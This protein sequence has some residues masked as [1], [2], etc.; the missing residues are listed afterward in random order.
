MDDKTFSRRRF[1]QK[2]L[3]GSLAVGLTSASG[4][5]AAE[6][7]ADSPEVA[8]LS[9]AVT[10]DAKQGFYVTVL[11]DGRAIAQHSKGGEFSAYFQNEERSVEDRVAP[12]KATLWNGNSQRLTTRGECKLR[13]LNTTVYA[14]VD[15]AVVTPHVLR[16]KIRLQQS[17]MFM[18]HYQLSNRLEAAEEPAKFWS[19][20]HLDWLGESSR[21][22]FP[23]GGFRTKNGL[24]VG[25]LTDS[26]Y[27]NQWT[28]IIRRDGR[29]VKPAPARI[30]DANL[31]SAARRE[32]R[33]Q[34]D[35]FI[36]QTFGELL[37]QLPGDVNGRPITLPDISSWKKHGNAALEAVGGVAALST[38]NSETGVLIP[39]TAESPALYS[40]DVQY[41]SPASIAIE[42]WNVDEQL[43]KITYITLYNDGL[44]PSR[45]T[46]NDF[47]TTVFVP[48]L[49]GNRF[50][51]FISVAPSEQGK[52][53]DAPSDSSSIEIQGLRIG[54]VVTRSQPYHRLEMGQA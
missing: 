17:D 46:W 34:G 43:R 37:E 8:G 16:K 42:I 35:F 7:A 22:Y 48:G 9:L 2:S 15:Y 27:R 23:A 53:A 12:W 24:C 20:D 47:K 28:R 33:D 52:T 39:F 21:E 51:V 32:Q 10:G 26:G 4:F 44:P 1:I 25:L 5:A 40:L 14:Q 38:K 41:R 36:Q 18:L 31:Y 30:P 3:K 11:H 29:P 13:N 50:A 19:F 49:R 54:H 45:D 6:P